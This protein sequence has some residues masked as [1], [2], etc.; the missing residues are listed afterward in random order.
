MEEEP[1]SQEIA[2]E[3]P[4]CSIACPITASSPLRG[5]SMGVI[6]PVL[7]GVSIL[8]YLIVIS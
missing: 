6:E 4:A 5:E 2:P 1:T 3:A 7:I 8:A